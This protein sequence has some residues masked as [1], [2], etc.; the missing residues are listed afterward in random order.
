LPDGAWG[1]LPQAG[2][3]YV[4]CEKFRAWFEASSWKIIDAV[5]MAA[6]TTDLGTLRNQLDDMEM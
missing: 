2:G 4:T 3:F 5:G 1:V 6:K